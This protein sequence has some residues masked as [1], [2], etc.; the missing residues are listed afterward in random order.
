MMNPNSTG[1]PA[2]NLHY[3][4]SQISILFSRA[5][6]FLLAA[7]MAVSICSAASW[8]V[9]LSSGEKFT[10]IEHIYLNQTTLYLV[11]Q[12]MAVNELPIPIYLGDIKKIKHIRSNRLLT[13]IGFGYV[14]WGGS[15]F[16]GEQ[17]LIENQ[18]KDFT[19]DHFSYSGLA[20]GLLIGARASVVKIRL[21]GK[22]VPERQRVVAKLLIRERFL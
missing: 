14:A 19:I 21:A 5:T 16:L 8:Q 12:R 7:I 11:P 9:I 18:S 6:C 22:D 17:Y 4:Q 20:I 15:K 13:A 10:R 1:L 3:R 2:T